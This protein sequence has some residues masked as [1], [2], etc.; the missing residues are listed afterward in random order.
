MENSVNLYKR[1]QSV[2]NEINNIEKKM[3]VG[4]GNY[5][6][7]AV[8]DLDVILKVKRAETKYGVISIPIKQEIISHETLKVS[9]SDG[10]DST[11][12]ADIIKMTVRIINIDNPE[13]FIDV[14]SFGR[15]LD[16]GDKG[17]GKASTYAR[18][19]ALLNAY[20]IA[21]GEDPDSDKSKNLNVIKPDAMKDSVIG[22]L[23][24][25]Y[26]YCQ[27][28]LSYFN[29]A[30]VDDLTSVQIDRT[31]KTLQKKNMI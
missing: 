7:K 29:A 24:S 8:G 30:S 4:K 3:I 9:K 11:S 12:F 27:N 10:G 14:E 19:Y 1:I 5:Q 6:Y 26:D 22:Y 13:E 18:K 25:N 21:T 17:F 28:L 20:K 2:S 23:M 16:S 31:F 15:G